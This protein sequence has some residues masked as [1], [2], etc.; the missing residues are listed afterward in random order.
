MRFKNISFVFG[1]KKLPIVKN[2]KE[3]KHISPKVQ[4]LIWQIASKEL[5]LDGN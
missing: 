4:A 3:L 2:Y 5:G 1:Q